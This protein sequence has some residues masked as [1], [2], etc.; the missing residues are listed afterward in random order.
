MSALSSTHLS[1]RKVQLRARAQA[2]RREA[3]D[4]RGAAACAAATQRL[5]CYLEALE[6]PQDLSRQVIAGYMPIGSELDP[7]PAMTALSE[8]VTLSVPVVLG[9]GQAL[10]FDQ[11]TPESPMVEGAYGAKVPQLS[12]PVTPTVVI[13]PMLA[14]DR[15]GHRLGYGGG[16]YDRTLATLRATAPVLAL[17]FAYAA[18]EVDAVP[19]EDTD[20]P[21]DALVTD[22]ALLQF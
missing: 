21:L 3:H 17:G 6:P 1:K 14:F 15:S 20:A 19:V 10:R 12:V 7:R 8:R 11:W 5:L 18:Q 22:T 13:V 2:A 9:A 4:S 16:Y